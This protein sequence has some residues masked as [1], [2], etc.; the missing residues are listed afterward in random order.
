[1]FIKIVI[2]DHSYNVHVSFAHHSVM[3][4]LFSLIWLFFLFFFSITWPNHSNQ[5]L[6]IIL[7]K[8]DLLSNETLKIGCKD[9]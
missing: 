7:Q 3:C 1:M 5:M 8:N 2:N 9:K 4:I 6:Y